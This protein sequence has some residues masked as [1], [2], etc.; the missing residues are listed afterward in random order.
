MDKPEEPTAREQIERF[1]VEWCHAAG[2]PTGYVRERLAPL[3]DAHRREVIEETRGW[4]S[5]M[6][7]LTGP[8]P[9]SRQDLAQDCKELER[10]RDGE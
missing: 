4:V 9:Y 8:Y 3:L 7:E 5:S 10:Q 2:A 6:M 1:V